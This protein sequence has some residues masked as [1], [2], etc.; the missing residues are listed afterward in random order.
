MKKNTILFLEWHSFGTPFIMQAFQKAGYSVIREAFP[1][2]KIDTR[3]DAEYTEK[4]VHL[5]M[6]KEYA[7]VFTINYFPVAAIACKA[8]RIPYVSWTYDSPF[9][10]LY[11]K[12]LEFD[13]NFVFVFDSHTV[14]ELRNMG[15]GNVYY[16]PMA[17]PED[18]YENMLSRKYNKSRY[19]CD[20]AFVGS[21][22]SED[23]HNPFRKMKDLTGYYK[24]LVD[25]LIQ[26]QRKVYGYQFL[27]E[28]L[29]E[30]PDLVEQIDRL[31]PYLIAGDGLETIE[32][33]YANYYL[34]RQVTAL[35]RRILLEQMAERFHTCV[36]TPEKSRIPHAETKGKADYYTEA[37][38]VYHNSKINLNITL[39]SIQTGIPLRAFDIMGCGG[40][41][42]SNWQED[43]LQD[44]EPGEDM[45][46]YESS[47]EAVDKAAFYLGHE[48]ERCRIAENGRQK[49]R[50]EHTYL[51]RIKDMCA[52][53]ED[54]WS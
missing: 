47:E 33:V 34:L 8:C 31:C 54:Y 14:Q 40:F 30:M 3:N 21:L 25:G 45:V 27:Q 16:L 15:Y 39:R 22:Y 51:H 43:F 48:T 20:V 2:D 19:Q 46:L 42:L 35:D 11:S 5:I 24:G 4:L 37:P 53:I 41:L 26:A 36:Y 32:W 28:I 18:D 9:A 44:F 29:E 6:D 17:V 52:Y 50:K 10:Q 38:Y 7:C 23:F 49:V 1:R 13:T 12:T